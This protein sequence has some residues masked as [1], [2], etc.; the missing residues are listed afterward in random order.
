[1]LI[2]KKETKQHYQ[3]YSLRIFLFSILI[4]PELWN[5]RYTPQIWFFYLFFILFGL[6]HLNKWIKYYASF[7]AFIAFINVGITHKQY[8]SY[9]REKTCLFNSELEKMKNKKVCVK[10]GWLKSFELRLKEKEIDYHFCKDEKK[11]NEFLVFK[12]DDFSNWKYK[13]ASP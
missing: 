6:I 12:G 13:I 8:L 10:K 4:Q 3:E 5:Y 2:L 1:M 9:N 7:V 11:Q